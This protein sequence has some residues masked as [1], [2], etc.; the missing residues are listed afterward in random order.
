M[1]LALQK[2]EIFNPTI[3]NS[4]HS[5]DKFDHNKPY[6]NTTDR[7]VI[8]NRRYTGSIA[9]EATK[10]FDTNFNDHKQLLFLVKVGF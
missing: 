7:F 4:H 6:Q 3:K 2:T 9:L 8:N 10:Y 5:L 1:S